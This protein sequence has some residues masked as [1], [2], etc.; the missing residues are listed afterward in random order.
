MEEKQSEIFEEAV[1]IP[2]D[3]VLDLHAFQPREVKALVADYIE[4][5]LKRGIYD[6]RII[7]GKGTGTLK[8]IVHSVL[9]KHPA[10]LAFRDADPLSGGWGATLVTLKKSNIKK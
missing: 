8:A 7:H 5:C 2:V 9:K 6:L 1:E 3:G 10:V 4:E